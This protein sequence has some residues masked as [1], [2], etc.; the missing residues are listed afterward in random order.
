MKFLIAVA[1]FIGVAIADGECP[2]SK[3]ITCVDDVRAAYPP[4]EKAAQAQGSDTI[5]D[6]TCLKYFNK[7]K[8]DCWPCICK[9]AEID[10]FKIKGC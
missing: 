2:E 4:C 7:M 10:H 6:I 5:A 1:A 3:Q 8:A 9:I